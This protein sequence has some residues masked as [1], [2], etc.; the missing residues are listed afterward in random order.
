MGQMGFPVSTHPSLPQV[1]KEESRKNL[2]M[3]DEEVIQRIVDR[4]LDGSEPSTPAAQGGPSR[5]PP[6]KTPAGR[7][8][9]NRR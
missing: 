1:V 9:K 2:T 3:P 5:A 4:V 8:R 6:N 7:G